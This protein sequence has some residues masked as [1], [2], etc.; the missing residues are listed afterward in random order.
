IG[1]ITKNGILIVEFTHQQ[2]AKGLSLY[3]AVL[4]ASQA[5]LRPILMTSFTAAFG[6]VPIAMAWGAGAESRR[7]M[8]I[9]VAGGLLFGMVLTLYVIPAMILLFAS[10]KQRE[11]THV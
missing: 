2:M 9:A 7:P 1:L 11:A 8:G 6:M 10:K 4:S 5:R 3:D